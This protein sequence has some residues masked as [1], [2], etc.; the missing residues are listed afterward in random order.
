MGEARTQR[1]GKMG[2]G[3]R[4][5]AEGAGAENFGGRGIPAS[6]EEEAGLRT[7][8]GVPPAVEHDAGNVALHVES[9]GRKHLGELVADSA[10]VFAEGSGEKFATAA[11]TLRFGRKSRIRK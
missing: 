9:N 7:Q 5:G 11:M 8:I 3:E 1:A 6:T 10:F 2:V 4:D